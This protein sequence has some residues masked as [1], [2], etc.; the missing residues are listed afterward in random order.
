MTSQ[1]EFSFSFSFPSS[2]EWVKQIM[3]KQRFSRIEISMRNSITQSRCLGTHLDAKLCLA[4]LFLDAGPS[5]V[6][7][8]SS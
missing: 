8:P 1:K 3:R 6:P 7:A 5:P 2:S 4:M